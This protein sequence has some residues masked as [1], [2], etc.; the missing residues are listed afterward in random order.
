M[1][2]FIEKS[3][4]DAYVHNRFDFVL[5]DAITGEVKETFESYNILLNQ[6]WVDFLNS[7]NGFIFTK[8]SF[9]TGTT[10]PLVTDTGLTAKLGSKNLTNITRDVSTLFIDNT[11]KIRGQIRIEAN[12]YV[13]TNIAEVG[14]AN[15]YDT[16]MTKSLIV[17]MNGNP[18]VIP[19]DDLTVVDIYAT[20]FGKFNHDLGDGVKAYVSP[21][22]AVYGNPTYS[23]I[24]STLLLNNGFG[25]TGTL[26]LL[27]S[28]PVDYPIS[29]YLFTSSVGHSTSMSIT[30]NPSQKK[31]TF[32]ASEIAVG[33]GNIGGFGS[34][35]FMGVV[36][37]LPNATA[38]QT[39][40]LK[41]VIGVGDGVNKEFTCAFQRILPGTATLYV[42]DV[43]VSADFDYLTP[44][45]LE[46]FASYFV[47]VGDY[48]GNPVFRN[49]IH[50]KRKVEKFYYD[51]W[52]GYENYQCWGSD[53]PTGPF[54]QVISSSPG[55]DETKDVPADKQFEYWY[56]TGRRDRLTPQ[57]YS[58]E[59]GKDIRADIA[60]GVGSTVSLTYTPNCIAKDANSLF[61]NISGSLQFA[62]YTPE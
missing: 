57:S 8:L 38:V 41:E 35:E 49:T 12:E 59:A 44:S 25:S 21:V 47:F 10:I 13:G 29:P 7:R 34:A 55:G 16:L 32:T 52:N 36:W 51:V 33:S 20:F 61:R 45:K 48:S 30:H 62:E 14:I 56:F 18:L 2:N 42:D 53:S 58:H 50:N 37:P 5:R 27:A 46:K 28:M 40:I 9:G 26:N 11:V 54:V 1:N 22:T 31:I 3:H 43:P 15:Y 17:D 23:G 60:P 24:V 39:P 19:K 4:L 6:F